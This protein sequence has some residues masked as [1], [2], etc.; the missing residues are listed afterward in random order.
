[1]SAKRLVVVASVAFVGA[2][3]PVG[4]DYK[5][6]ETTV[7][8]TFENTGPWKLAEPGD[9]LARG[10]WWTLFNDPVL[11]ELERTAK[12]QSPTLAAYAARVD[13]ARAAAGI[14]DSFRYP[15]VN[16]GVIA[17]R[18]QAAQDRPDQPSKQLTNTQYQNDVFRVPVV[19][20]YEL[21]VWGRVR[22]Q[23]EAALARADSSAAEY[24][25]VALTLESEI[26]STYFRLRQADEEKRIFSQNIGLQQRARDLVAKRKAGGVA[27]EWISPGPTP[28]S[29]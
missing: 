27:S 20:S 26:A 8:A 13:Q 22:R 18:Y 5:R 24:Q 29:N 23:S 7:P 25:T 3:A 2:C 6:P 19:V 16:V 4:P 17:G 10:D 11:D 15:E 12:Q 1:M 14:A 21:D 9:L 28:N